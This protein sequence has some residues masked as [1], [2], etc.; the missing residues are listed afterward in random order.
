VHNTWELICGSVNN[1]A[2]IAVNHAITPE[3]IEQTIAT[4]YATLVFIMFLLCTCFADVI[5][6]H[7]GMFVFTLTVLPLLKTT[8]K[9][10]HTDVRIVVV[11]ALDRGFRGGLTNGL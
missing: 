5:V 10:P 6:S 9:L 11:S 2:C 4:K 3:G 1:A 8:A 7:V